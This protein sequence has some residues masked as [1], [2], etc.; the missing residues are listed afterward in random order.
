MRP[1]SVCLVRFAAPVF[2]IAC[3]GSDDGARTEGNLPRFGEAPGDSPGEMSQVP[4]EPA[5]VVDDRDDGQLLFLP[6]MAASRG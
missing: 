1:R 3:S 4:A 6:A 2:F 5:P